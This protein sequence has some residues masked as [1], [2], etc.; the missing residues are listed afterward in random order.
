MEMGK[1]LF[2]PIWRVCYRIL[3][4]SHGNR[5]SEILL[6]IFIKVR[7]IFISFLELVYLWEVSYHGTCI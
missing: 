4:S 1:I 5:I 2:R 3:S 6:L 7:I